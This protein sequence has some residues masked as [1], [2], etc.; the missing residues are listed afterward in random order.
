MF[1][2]LFGALVGY[3]LM[4]VLV[5]LYMVLAFVAPSF[6]FVPGKLETTLAWSVMALV[7]CVPT[8]MAG[9]WVA[10]RI[11]R[12]GVRAAT[13]LVTAI[14][15]VGYSCATMTLVR[16]QKAGGGEPQLTAAQVDAM[17]LEERATRSKEPV[18]FTMLAPLLGALGAAIGGGIFRRTRGS[19]TPERSS[20]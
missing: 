9:G 5:S 3:A 10:R 19:V 2:S 14:L 11:D 20:A 12:G 17:P 16:E 7:L 1:R 18:W 6:V 8:G 15:V 13:W 4:V